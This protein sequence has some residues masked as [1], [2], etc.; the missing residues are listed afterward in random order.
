MLPYIITILVIVAIAVLIM[1]MRSRG[2][3]LKKE[4]AQYAKELDDYCRSQAPQGAANVLRTIKIRQSQLE[5]KDPLGLADF[6]EA[7]NPVLEQYKDFLSNLP[8]SNVD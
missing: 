7:I 8:A 6:N 3:S 2:N 5:I 4:G 1:L